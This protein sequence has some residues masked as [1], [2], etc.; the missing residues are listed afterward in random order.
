MPTNQIFTSTWTTPNL[1]NTAYDGR[2]HDQAFLMP[3]GGIDSRGGVLPGLVD[4]GTNNDLRVIASGTGLGLLVYPGW[5]VI[6]RGVLAPYVSYLDTTGSLELDPADGVNPR[7]DLIVARQYDK[8][9]GDPGTGPDRAVIE[10]V[11]GTPASIP[12]APYGALPTDGW[13][14][15][16]EVYVAAGATV[17]TNADITDVRRSAS[18][19]HGIRPLLT[20][21]PTNDPGAYDREYRHRVGAR[22]PEFWEDSTSTW[23]SLAP[24]DVFQTT[25]V[26]ALTGQSGVASIAS[27]TIPSPGYPYR[28]QVNGS[29]ELEAVNCRADL[30]VRVGSATGTTI[31]LGVGPEAGGTP[32]LRW[33]LT[34]TRVSDV[35]TGSQ[36]IHLVAGRA[37]GTGTWASSTFNGH[38]SVVRIPA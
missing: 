20:A 5:V 6:P 27:I 37:Y 11:T 17:V 2:R 22:G 25:A 10:V 19:R 15:L 1:S 23:R 33:T 35:L 31:A 21:D 16:A 18:I 9:A 12:A 34:Q 28:L 29:A 26:T 13:V 24:P 30:F 7:V 8:D 3:G 38:L 32:V 36:T 4:G 14:P